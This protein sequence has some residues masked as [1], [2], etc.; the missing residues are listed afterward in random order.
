MESSSRLHDV[1]YNSLSSVEPN[2]YHTQLLSITPTKKTTTAPN[3][4]RFRSLIRFRFRLRRPDLDSDYGGPFPI[5]AARFRFRSRSIYR[6]TESFRDSRF[7]FTVPSFGPDSRPEL[8]SRATI[9]ILIT[10]ARSRLPFPV[11]SI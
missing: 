4:F 7:R 1:D 6:S 2:K 5:T 8:R 10:A 11:R 3:S 9:K